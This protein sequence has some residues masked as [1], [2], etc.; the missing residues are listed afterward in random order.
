MTGV[1]QFLDH[2]AFEGRIA[3]LVFGHF[4]VEH[5]EAVV[6]LAG[7]DQILHAR[8]FGELNPFVGVELDRIELL[9]EIVVNLNGD[10]AGASVISPS[11]LAAAG[12]SD[13]GA[14]DDSLVRAFRRRTPSSQ[15]RGDGGMQN[16]SE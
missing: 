7:E 1:G 4:A 5:R 11:T 2:I 15:S 14:L 9:V 8:V 12:P 16:V 3:D 13:L 10:R 6:M